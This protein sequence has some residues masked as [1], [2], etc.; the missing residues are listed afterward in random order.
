VI[1]LRGVSKSYDLDGGRS[2]TALH[3]VDLNVERGEFLV[4]TGRS[5]SGKTTLLNVASGLAKP[6]T[7]T[8]LLDG[9]E[10][11]SLSDAEQSNIRN[12]KIGFVFQFP[13]LM[14]ALSVLAN[15]T[16]PR[17]F[18]RDNHTNG[19]E[20]GA[21]LLDMVGLADRLGSFPRQLSAGQQQRVVIARALVNRP[22]LL[23]ADEPSSDLDEETER[24]IMDLFGRVHKETGVTILMVTHTKQLVSYGTRHVEMAAGTLQPGGS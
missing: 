5:G 20:R 6:T 7:G 21:V 11:S 17:A 1:S 8:V 14:P 4:I 18:G 22:E 9:V 2:V 3:D 24:E 15:V 12:R 16:L 19:H 10:F 23:L 13:S